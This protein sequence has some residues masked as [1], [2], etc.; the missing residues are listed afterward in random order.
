MRYPGLLVRYLTLAVVVLVGRVALAADDL[1]STARRSEEVLAIEVSLRQ[2]AVLYRGKRYDELAQLVRQARQSLAGL[3]GEIDDVASLARLDAKITAAERLLGRGRGGPTTTTPSTT[4]GDQVSFTGQVAPLLLRSCGNC[5][6]NRA[7]GELSMATYQSFMAGT[8]DGPVFRPGTAK[9]SRLMDLV[10]SGEMPPNGQL[11]AE[12][13]AVLSNW[14]GQGAKFDGP[15]P[16]APLGTLVPQ[17]SGERPTLTVVKASSFDEVQFVRDLAPVIVGQCLRCHGDM[18]PQGRLTLA[19]F[20]GL[21]RGGDSG[22]AIQP[23][24]PDESLL[25]QKLKGSA[26]D[27]MPQ[28]RPPLDDAVIA[29]FERWIADGAKFDGDDENQALGRAVDLLLAREM[30]HDELAQR[31]LEIALANWRLAVPDTEPRHVET[32]HYLLI[33]NVGSGELSELAATAEELHDQVAKILRAADGEL[34]VKGRTTLHVF[35]RRFDYSEFGQMVERRQIPAQ[36]AGHWR[37]DVVDAYGCLPL[38]DD[39]SSQRALMAEQIAGVYIATLGSAPRWFSGGT[40]RA[41]AAR[42]E[43]RCEVVRQ[44]DER[45]KPAL[46]GLAKPDAFL[47]DDVGTPEASALG[48]GFVDFLMSD[49]GRFRGLLTDL[50]RGGEFDVAV[51]KAFGADASQLAGICVKRAGR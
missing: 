49:A 45:I 35:G 21:L 24:K 8:P 40:A 36:S 22:L 31:R 48:F 2:A 38:S 11:D 39:E 29:Q 25:I 17:T 7:R 33:G 23:G 12:Q 41:V 26:G 16:Q 13:M 44:W 19:T 9:G 28:G 15:D 5:H 34:P 47:T 32:D 37:Y 42:V 14:I 4:P 30:N 6:V 51:R 27:R 10:E 20:Q 18:Q 1:A 50:S 43:R 3:S 46:F